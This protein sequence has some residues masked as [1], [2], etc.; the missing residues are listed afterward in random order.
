MKGEKEEN[1]KR[2]EEKAELRKYK[3]QHQIF[4]AIV[5]FWMLLIMYLYFKL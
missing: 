3:A 1:E 5:L 4:R 2:M